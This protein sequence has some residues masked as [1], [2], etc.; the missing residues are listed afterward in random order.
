VPSDNRCRT[1][2][3]VSPPQCRRPR[4]HHLHRRA[5]PSRRRRRLLLRPCRHRRSRR[6]HHRAVSHRQ[7]LPRRPSHRRLPR[8]PRRRRD[9]RQCRLPNRGIP[10]AFRWKRA[11]R[12]TGGR[13]TSHGRSPR[14]RSPRLHPRCVLHR[15]PHRPRPRYRARCRRHPPQSNKRRSGRPAAFVRKRPAKRAVAALPRPPRKAASAA[16]TNRK[17]RSS[18]KSGATIAAGADSARFQR[19]SGLS[20]G[21]TLSSIVACARSFGWMR[22]A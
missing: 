10:V 1:R 11:C 19:S 3:R 6:L 13:K 17:A 22:S 15:R 4:W 18:A 16:R 7:R 14:R 5:A 20:T 12:Y 21:H 2:R 9:H 8:C